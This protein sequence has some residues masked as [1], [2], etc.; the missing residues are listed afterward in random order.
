MT[1]YTA[2]G[3]LEEIFDAENKSASFTSREFI[4]RQETNNPQYPNFLKFQLIQDRCDLI[5]AYEQGSEIR[6]HFN[7]VGKKWQDKVFTNLQAWKLEHT[8]KEVSR[9]PPIGEPKKVEAK[10]PEPASEGDFSDLPF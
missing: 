7:L 2:E 8:S 4:V 9:K 10:T 1:S 3:V 6:V 5:D